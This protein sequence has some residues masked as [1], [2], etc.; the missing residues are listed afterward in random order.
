M[1]G[2]YLTH[3]RG[4]WTGRLAAAVF[5]AFVIGTAFLVTIHGGVA[6]GALRKGPYLIYPGVNTEMT[7]LWQL[8]DTQSCTLEWGEDTVYGD[9]CVITTE[10]G[11]DHQ[12]SYTITNLEPGAKYHYLV[13]CGSGEYEGSFH[14]APPA[15]ADSVKILVYGDTRTYPFDH[16]AVNA[17]MINTYTYDPDYQTLSLFVGNWVTCSENEDDWTSEFFNENALNTK[18]F[19]ANVPINGCKGNH[20]G[21][22]NLYYKYWPYPYVDNFYW[23]F[24]YGPIHVAVVDQSTSYRSGSMQYNWLVNDLATSDKP[25]KFILLH[26]PGWSAGGNGNNKDVQD[27]IQ[28]LCLEYGVDIVIA[29]QNH[30]YA[31]AEVDGIRHITTGGGGAP[32][33][34]CDENLPFVVTASNVHHFCEVE[35]H[36][37][38]L[39]FAAR[40]WNGSVVDSF[41][42]THDTTPPGQVTGLSI[43]TVSG[44]RL[45]L[46][47]GANPEED[48]DHYNVYRSTTMGSGHVL[49]VSPSTSSYSDTELTPSTTYYYLVTAVD[50]SSN[51]GDPSSEENGTTSAEGSVTIDW[52][53][54][55]NDDYPTDDM[56]VAAQVM[57][58]DRLPENPSEQ[59]CSAAFNK[60]FQEVSSVGGG[61]VYAAEGQYLFTEP[62][63][64]SPNVVL[65]GEWGSVH[66]TDKS[67]RG[68]ILK[69]A[70]DGLDTDNAPAFIQL[71]YRAGLK[72]LTIWYPDQ[73][74]S[75]VIPYTRTIDGVTELPDEINIQNVNL[76]NSYI[77]LAIR[78]NARRAFCRGLYG[79][80]LKLGMYQ[81]RSS[82]VPFYSQVYFSAEYWSESG[83]PSAPD[84]DTELIPYLQNNATAIKV[85]ASDNVFASEWHVAD[86]E[87]GFHFLDEGIGDINGNMY[88]FYVTNCKTA[89]RADNVGPSFIINSIFEGSDHAV[90]LNNLN[91]VGVFFNN[92]SFSSSG[93]AIYNNSA[94]NPKSLRFQN[95]TF[96]APL[97]AGSSHLSVVNSTFDE[98]AGE[99]PIKLNSDTGSA[100]LAG[101]TFAYDGDP[102]ELNGASSNI[103]LMDE[104]DT[105]SETY[106]PFDINGYNRV[107]KPYGQN[108]VVMGQNGY[109]VY[110]DGT[111]DDA[112]VIQKALD[113]VHSMGGGI[114][115]LPQISEAGYAIRTALT[116]PAGVELRSTSEGL[117][118]FNGWKETVPA[119]MLQI[120]HGRNASDPT[121]TLNEG[122]GLKG[123]TIHYPEQ[124]MNS[125]TPYS[126]TVKAV[127][128]GAYVVNNHFVNSYAHVELDGS[129]N[130]LVENNLGQYIYRPFTVLN[131]NNGRFNHNVIRDEWE[132][133]RLPTVG[134]LDQ[135][136]E[137]SIQNNISYRVIDS[138]N[139]QFFASFSR[140]SE[141][142][143]IFQ[144]SSVHALQFSMEACQNGIFIDG[145]PEG[146]S[147]ELIGSSLR[148]DRH[149]PGPTLTTFDV[150]TEPGDGDFRVFSALSTGYH[151]MSFG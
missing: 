147:V 52:Q 127:G 131:C 26:E 83:L 4:S 57:T 121:I 27:H 81:A 129:D 97:I 54:V 37:N 84:K 141:K 56:V 149:I 133:S 76:V 33:Y 64:I 16:D 109:D 67:V 140:V 55:V 128:D 18:E 3:R 91:S 68:T 20:E 122:S 42:I 87:T 101:N 49:V 43:T 23:S 137:Y 63:I 22:G 65:R 79:S 95:C 119:A 110:V 39:Y 44:T 99:Q 29:G 46:T 94:L 113:D 62:L 93:N 71:D 132:D 69:V 41:T 144:N 30:F 17:E 82:S 96:D 66:G 116:V 105:Y 145:I 50:T 10:Y 150:S 73:S 28:T 130:H 24:D 36:G 38:V 86:Y 6:S 123:F 32:L 78:G 5:A 115:L 25:W 31:R 142:L 74:L 138:T 8:D 89:L 77:G 53:I 125:I 103:V 48:L 114:V 72:N 146:E 143:A 98:S 88:G 40:D 14:A 35:I 90:L 106:T 139:Q 120:Y 34:S 61:V 19:Q 70:Y 136:E 124:Q 12:H 92:V 85:G 1:A 11:N 15:G 9:G 45:D 104:R 118:S 135:L 51:E 100:I 126:V 47:W 117:H 75:N 7:V 151:R 148:T 21:D 13:T 2:K 112:P 134:D 108:L 107:R 102:V 111:T 59:D 58:P 60:A 80:P